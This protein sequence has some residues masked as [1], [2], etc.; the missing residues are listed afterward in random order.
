MAIKGI[1]FDLYGTLIDIETDEGLEEIFR[2]IG[3]Y[4]VYCGIVLTPAEVRSRYHEL[5]KRNMQENR[6]EYPEFDALA[7]WSAFLQEAGM[8]DEAERGKLAL[9]LSQLF[10]GL[11]RKRLLLFPDVKQV[12]DGLRTTYRLA[13]VSDAQPC[14]AL[15]EIKAVGLDGY[16]DP[17]VISAPR[18]FRK[19]DPRMYQEALSVMGLTPAEAIFVG[20][21][22]FRDTFG[23]QRVGLKTVFF[24]SNSG[25]QAHEKV[26]PD[27][28]VRKFAEV[29]EGID[30]LTRLA[31]S[32]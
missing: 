13:L 30:R 5:M 8:K 28:F 20:N 3:H 6:A 22:M 18:G 15:P 24:S 7:L 9:T 32:H 25:A 2:G 17:I 16:F 14:Y 1:L 21:D 31:T 19:P 26:A 29:K 27:V 23:A 11:S 12:L 10:R 4:L